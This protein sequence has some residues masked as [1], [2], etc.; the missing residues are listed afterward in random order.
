MSPN[1]SN[2]GFATHAAWHGNIAAIMLLEAAIFISSYNHCVPLAPG[3]LPDIDVGG[4]FMA[5]L[6]RNATA[7][8]NSACHLFGSA[9]SESG[10]NVRSICI[11][12]RLPVYDDM[13]A[14]SR[15]MAVRGAPSSGPAS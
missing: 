8:P 1:R 3:A 7:Y 2:E 15:P 9:P 11:A 5:R 6:M 4:D 10:E 12:M 13:V 14:L